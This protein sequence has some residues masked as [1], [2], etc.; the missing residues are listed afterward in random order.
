MT[1]ALRLLAAL[2][3]LAPQ[4]AGAACRLALALGLDVSGSVDD[5]EYRLQVHGLA[6]ALRHPEVE[7][8]FLALPDAPVRLAVFEWSGAGYRRPLVDWTV[9]TGPEALH[10]AAAQIAATTRTAA[11]PETALGAAMAH[12]AE[13]LSRQPDCWR[14]VL[15][16]SGDGKHNVPPHPRDLRAALGAQGLT[17]NALVIGSDTRHDADMAQV[18]IGQLIAYFDAWVILGPEAFVEAALGFRDY[19][20]AMTRK[21]LREL[22]TV[23]LSG[24]RPSGQGQSRQDRLRLRSPRPSPGSPPETQAGAVAA[25]PPVADLT[26]ATAPR[27][28]AFRA[29]GRRQ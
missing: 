25:R 7:R 17:V 11:P 5:A 12:G 14:R 29:L 23:V 24:L 19:E 10:A 22:Q 6:N 1:T 3:A 9:I 8:A 4:A 20:A 28:R 27:T 16:I 2:F 13:L 15:D 26:T 18:E 21:L